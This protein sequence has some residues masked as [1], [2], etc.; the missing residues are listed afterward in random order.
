MALLKIFVF[1]FTFYTSA[2]A[3]TFNLND[4]L[5]CALVGKVNILKMK[6]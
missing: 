2:L 5:D 6:T 4:R 3:E 1:T